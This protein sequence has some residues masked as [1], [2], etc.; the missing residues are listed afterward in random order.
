MAETLK[1]LITDEDPDSRV[2]AR[3]ALQRAELAVAGEVGYG[4]AAVSVALET[5][6]D[7]ILLAV[8]EPVRRPLETAEALANALPETPFIFYSSLNDPEAIRRSMVFGARDYVVKPVQSSRLLESINTV[9][10]QEERRHMRRAGQLTG[11]EARGSVIT[12]TG[13]KGGIGK[14]VISVNLALTL[15]RET[16]QSVVILDGD[17]EFGDVATMLDLTPAHNAADLLPVIDRLDRDSIR[18]FVEVHSTG[19]H[20]LPGVSS[21][22]GTVRWDADTLRRAIDLLAQTYDFVIV[23]TAGAFDSTVRACLEASTL[24]LVVTTGEVSSIRDTATA[25]RRLR[26][27]RID[28]DRVKLLLNRGSRANGFKLADL[29]EAVGHEV[30]WE[31]PHDSKMATAIQFGQPVAIAGTSPAARN[32]A[33]LARR[34]AGTKRSLVEQPEVKAPAWNVLARWS[35]A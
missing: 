11:A 15:I 24:T 16:G 12:V 2:E 21:E 32:L 9:L 4:T 5:R 30:F 20:V 8:E 6:P 13:A 19:V 18:E 22:D 1:I 10:L 3:K 33:T 35:R 7:I 28:S 34:L 23:D 27:W 29:Q 25:M 31:L 14:T 26:T 17:T